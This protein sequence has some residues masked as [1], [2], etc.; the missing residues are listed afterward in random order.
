MLSRS[1]TVPIHVSFTPEASAEWWLA[2][3]DRWQRTHG[4]KSVRSLLAGRLPNSLA[5]C[6]CRHADIADNGVIAHVARAQ[7]L[8]LAQDLTALPLTVVGTEGFAKAIATQGGV[9]LA[10]VDPRDLQSRLL[11]GLY[12][13]GELL[14]LAGP[15][16]G[17]NLQWAFSSGY[18][19]GR[20]AGLGG[21]E[22]QG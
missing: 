3:F 1:A 18:L 14:D 2:T 9:S 5:E 7:R 16:G 6:L 22:G 4:R 8:R 13:A 19:A 10:E 17:Y 15:C 20:S 11:A 21:G 12:L